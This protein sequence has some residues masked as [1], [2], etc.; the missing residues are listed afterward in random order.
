MADLSRIHVRGVWHNDSTGGFDLLCD[1]CKPTSSW[2][3]LEEAYVEHS[4]D[5]LPLSRLIEIAEEHVRTRHG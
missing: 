5:S 1:D 4:D 3:E 2:I